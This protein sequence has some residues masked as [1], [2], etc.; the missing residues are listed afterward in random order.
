[1]P[2]PA[3]IGIKKGAQVG[4]TVFQHRHAIETEA[5]GEALVAHGIDPAHFEHAR[6]HHARAAEFEPVISCTE[7]Y[8]PARAVAT[9]VPFD[10]RLRERKERR[11][12]AQLD[13]V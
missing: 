8:L 7:F 11:P 12:G 13:L 3:Q 1:M 4:R 9:H 5:K 10:A 2:E 6:M